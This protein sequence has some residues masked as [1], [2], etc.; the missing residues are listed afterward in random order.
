MNLTW[1]TCRLRQDLATTVTLCWCV[2]IGVAASIGGGVGSG[3]TAVGYNYS[4]PLP[5]PRASDIDENT[6]YTNPCLCNF[7]YAIRFIV[8]QLLEIPLKIERSRGI[9]NKIISGPIETSLLDRLYICVSD[10]YFFRWFHDH[11]IACLSFPSK[12]QTT[13]QLFFRTALWRG[14]EQFNCRFLH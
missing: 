1:I 2:T 10:C 12:W 4:N 9:I 8:F 14:K 7:T 13:V 6:R 3:V 11:C 5:P